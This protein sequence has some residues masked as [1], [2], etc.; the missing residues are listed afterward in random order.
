MLKNGLKIVLLGPQASG[1][2]MQSKL[3]SEV[4]NISKVSTGEIFRKEIIDGT[5]IGKEIE[6]SISSGILISNDLTFKVLKKKL[7][8]M[9]FRDGFILDGYPRS[10]EQARHLEK[11]V[12]IDFVV[13]IN[14]S[15]EESVKRIENRRVCEKCG[16]SYDLKI[17]PPKKKN[18]CDKCDGKIIRRID[19]Y[20]EAIRK[21]LLIYREEVRPIIRFY[22]NKNILISVNG[23]NEFKNVFNE[24]KEK[25]IKKMGNKIM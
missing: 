13:L 15:N 12:N 3:L 7:E 2:G 24:I 17:F 21:R 16:K 8:S 19:D 1:K 5:K 23:D 9:N 22:K 10:I 20:P 18:K 6:E 14:I 4:L 11:I 25:M